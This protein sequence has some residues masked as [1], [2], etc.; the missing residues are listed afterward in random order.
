MPSIRFALDGRSVQAEVEP[1]MTALEVLRDRFGI[2]T[3]KDG[4]SPQ[5]ACGCCTAIVNGRAVM[6]CVK[7]AELLDGAEVTT[8]AGLEESKR[9]TLAR[10]FTEVG[11]LQCGFCTPGIAIR[12]ATLLDKQPDASREAIRG[13]LGSHLCRCTGYQRVVDAIEVAGRRWQQPDEPALFDL[14]LQRYAGGELTLGERAFVDDLEAEGLLHGALRLTDHPR[15]RVVAVDVAPAMA[16]PGVVAVLTAEDL[17]AARRI[18][19]IRADWDV[20][21]GVGGVTQCVG[22]A[23]ASVVAETRAAARAGAAA[24]AVDYEV[25]EPVTDPEAALQDGAPQVHPDF[26]NLVEVCRIDRGDVDAA[27]A[28]STHVLSEVFQSQR[29]EHAFVE[30]E[31]CVVVPKGEGIQVFTQGQGVHE[32]Q[33]Q[34]AEALG[35]ERERVEVTL[36]PSGGGFGGKEDLSVQ[37][38][39]AL[40]AVRAGRPVKL[41]LSRDESMRLHPKRHPLTMQYTVGCDPEGRLTAVKARLVGDTGGYLSVGTKV[42][43]RAAGHSCGPY[44]VPSVQVEAL[45]VYTNNPTCGAFRGFGVNQ[46]AF[47]IDGMLDR[48]A[49]LVGLDG[50]AIRE[51]NILEEGE[52]FATG[53]LM[54]S[55]IG[56]RQCLEAVREAYYGAEYAGIGCGIKNTGIGN[57]MADTGRVL[58]R[59]EGPERLAVYTGFTEMGQGLFTVLRGVVSERTGVP[60][61]FISVE[62]STQ[63]AVLCGMTTASRATMLTVEAAR[64]ACLGMSE[65]LE[66]SGMAELVGQEFAGEFVCD[67]TVAPGGDEPNPVTHVAFGYAA[68]VVVLREDGTL[69][70]VV[71]AHDVGRVMNRVACEG[72]IEGG[73]HMGLGFALTEDLP[74]EGGYLVSTRLAD[75]GLIKAKHTPEIEVVLI[76]VPDPHTEYG[77]KGVGEIGLVP[78]APAVAGALWKFDGIRRRVLPMRGSAAARVMLPRRLR[79]ED[80]A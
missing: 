74:S 32:D 52:A 44:R 7:K 77:V 65:A 71:A 24:I 35:W 54:D 79:E 20:Y 6:T 41:T 50:Y 31:S 38:H 34:I 58:L 23:L 28:K 3:V 11:G 56:I 12:A 2:T 48:L 62:T 66:G 37:H 9:N 1:E 16:I 47:A 45:T 14:A 53:Q 39:A 67:F 19:H 78:T 46:T 72:Q 70:K 60:A 30:P 69:A 33:R 51:R 4:C 17:P 22:S 64:R 59:V 63:Y 55:G 76:E 68:Q 10:A 40:L 36:V 80:H 21:V 25:L 57:G 26:P 75:L 18:G 43:E 15:A 61:E 8:L 27:L 5:A 29:V 49:E 73:V 42:L 13:A